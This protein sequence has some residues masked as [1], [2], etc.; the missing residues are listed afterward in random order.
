[1]AKA[2]ESDTSDTDAVFVVGSETEPPSP[3]DDLEWN[4][5]LCEGDYMENG[6]SVASNYLFD[7]EFDDDS[8]DKQLVNSERK[9]ING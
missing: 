8:T 7:V 1:M 3:F 6:E 2:Q 4:K 5:R 9:S